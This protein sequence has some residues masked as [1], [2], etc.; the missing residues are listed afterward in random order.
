MCLSVK[1]DPSGTAWRTRGVRCAVPEGYG[2]LFAY[3]PTNPTVKM[4]T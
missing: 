3:Y 4:M 2:Q 1:S